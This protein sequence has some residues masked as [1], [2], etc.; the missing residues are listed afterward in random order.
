MELSGVGPGGELGDEIELAKQ[1][2]H[3]LA[4]VVAFAQLLELSH[5]AR[6]GF[7]RLSDG[8]IRVVLTL[9]FQAVVML[10]Q[11]LPEEV[12]ETLTRGVPARLRA[13]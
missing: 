7:F 10:A 2:A 3:H 11:F 6:Q 5:D 9:A 1:L 13:R 4:G 8:P 12:G